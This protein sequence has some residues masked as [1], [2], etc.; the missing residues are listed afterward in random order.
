[1]GSIGRAIDLTGEGS[2]EIYREMISLLE[3][4]PKLD[5]VR[6]HDFGSRLAKSGADQ[7]FRTGTELLTWW[8]SRLIRTLSTADTAYGPTLDEDERAEFTRLG[9]AATLDRW[10]QV[11]DKITRL[12]ART[13]GANLDHK[14]VV[15]NVFLALED[16]VRP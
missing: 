13:G 6:L 5:A 11:W 16:T 7:A 4:L 14:Q 3:T 1:E 10:L 8:L 2:L 15:L 9:H 12:L